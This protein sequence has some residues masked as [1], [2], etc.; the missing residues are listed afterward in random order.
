[1]C[2]NDVKKRKDL[3]PALLCFSLL[4]LLHSSG[5]YAFET[6][7]SDTINDP[8][9]GFDELWDTVMLDITIMGVAFAALTL[10]F[11]FR[12]RRKHPDQVGDGPRFSAVQAVG[13]A[14][15]P[16]FIFMADDFY[17]AAKGWQLWNKYRDV[18]ADRMEVKLESGMYSWDY[19]YP[20]GIQT[21]NLL[22][23]PAGKPIMLRMT[24][25][26]TIHSHFLARYRVKEDSMPGR[27]TYLWFYP[28]E[29]DIGDKDNLVTCTEFC[30]VMH[31][32]MIGRIEVMVPA[33]FDQWYSEEESRLSRKKSN[34]TGESMVTVTK[35]NIEQGS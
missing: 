27:V 24:S 3:Y 1:M 4:F 11:M 8:A 32:Y 20:N 29:E 7:L 14:L 5:V 17:L 16:A 33:E 19:T 26:D 25:R 2:K 13:W 34:A 18:P 15:I 9:P 35:K 28:K 22:R 31:S 6:S 10:W 30:G 21:Q 12:Y 23:V